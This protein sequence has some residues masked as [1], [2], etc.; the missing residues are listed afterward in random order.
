[1]L[2]GCYSYIRKYNF[3]GGKSWIKIL[4][5]VTEQSESLQELQQLRQAYTLKAGGALS[6]LYRFLPLLSGGVR[7]TNCSVFQP[8]AHAVVRVPAI[9][10]GNC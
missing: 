3:K 10:A 4:E 7:L 2:P 6:D 9:P 8:A 1:M 5:V